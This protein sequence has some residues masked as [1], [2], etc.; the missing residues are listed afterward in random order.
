MNLTQNIKK[1]R[2][3]RDELS[4]RNFR[5]ALLPVFLV[6]PLS[7]MMGDLR[8]I[9]Q[10]LT[11]LGV[12]SNNLI[13]MV[14][15]L[16]FLPVFFTTE[17]H[18]LCLLRISALTQA[19]FLAAQIF[20][21]PG[22]ARLAVYFAFHFANAVCTTCGFYLFAFRLNNVER[23]FTMGATQIY[24][25]FTYLFWQFSPV[26]A[27]MKTVGSAAVMLGLVAAVFWARD[28]SRLEEPPQ[29]GPTA[30]ESGV[31]ILI[32]LNSVYYVITLTA[33]YI[34]YQE[35]AVSATL[36]GVGGLLCLAI[37][38][39]V[40]LIF[41]RSALHLWSLCLVCSVLG[42]GALH[43]TSAFAVNAGSLFYG[44]G[45]GLGF[46]I[47]YY[48]GGG[49]IRRSGS[50]RLLQIWCLF[51]G[52]NYV[53]ISG[54]FFTLYDNINAPNLRLAFPAVLVL[55]LVCYLFSPVL[56]DKLFR[57]DWTDGYHMANMPIYAQALAQTE[58]TD[59]EKSFCFTPREQEVFT[60]L[61][62]ET[63]PKQIATILRVSNATVN[64]HTKNIYRKLG[65]QSRTE[66]F[67]GY[68]H[69]QTVSV[70]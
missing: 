3:A 59:E 9:D 70:L 49:A 4:P 16:G 28:I 57:T 65:I 6:L 11:L 67:A 26:A 41:N 56:Q 37:S 47:L 13:L 33:M 2:S 54:V 7:I 58:Q 20:M 15:G 53:V 63:S 1:M 8:F 44:L 29:S 17:R 12:D 52:V 55:A 21:G 23:L 19:V 22:F 48:L 42:I 24:Y 27:F 38:F 40:M 18:Q 62:T 68:G 69:K 50:Y 35:T 36:Y 31:A 61:L 45:E 43:Y 10:N 60:L 32:L 14:F 25:A 5:A 66:L 39:F 46:M 34:E 51:L 30:R 64:F